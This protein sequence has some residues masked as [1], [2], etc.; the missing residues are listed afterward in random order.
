VG[1]GPNQQKILYKNADGYR[2]MA[3]K[4]YAWEYGKAYD[5]SV[6]AE[7]NAFVVQVNGEV[8][9]AWVDH[10]EPYLHG[11]IGLSNFCG[12]HTRYESVKV[13]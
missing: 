3:R 9:L 4:K 11:Q 2:P 6:T 5:H 10:E 13:S 7:G 12:C 1:I 8:L